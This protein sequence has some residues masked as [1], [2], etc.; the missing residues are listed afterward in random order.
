MKRVEIA[1]HDVSPDFRIVFPTT[2]VISHSN[3]SANGIFGANTLHHKK[4][5][6]LRTFGMSELSEAIRLKETCVFDINPNVI[7][8]LLIV[9]QENGPYREIAA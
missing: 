3:K 6:R 1:A 4:S 8:V 5:A 2:E 9:V 7:T